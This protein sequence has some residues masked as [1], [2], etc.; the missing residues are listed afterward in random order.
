MSNFNR[1]QQRPYAP[2]P[3]S[4]RG[5]G[6]TG[7]GGKG[8]GGGHHAGQGGGVGGYGTAHRPAA[9]AFKKGRF[10]QSSFRVFVDEATPDVVEAVFNGDAFIEWQNVRQVDLFC[11]LKPRCPICLEE[12]MVVPK[13]TRCG[14]IFCAP[15]IMRYF[16]VLT[17]QNER[18]WQRCPVCNEERLLPAEDLTSV[19]FQVT[20]LLREN[21]RLSLLLVQREVSAT[22]VRPC[23]GALSALASSLGAEAEEAGAAEREEARAAEAVNLPFERD[24]GW[25]FSRLVRLGPGEAEELLEDE[26]MVLRQYRPF[27]VQGGE[28]E[29]L[30]SIDAA[31]KLVENRLR[32]LRELSGEDPGESVLGDAA[33][34]GRPPEGWGC[35]YVGVPEIPLTAEEKGGKGGRRRGHAEPG[36][37]TSGAEAAAAK[38]QPAE[39]SGEAEEV[40]EEALG[41]GGDVP[42]GG[43]G[44]EDGEDEAD[45]PSSAAASPGGGPQVAPSGS[46]SP[47]AGPQLSPPSPAS[48]PLPTPY[49]PRLVSFYQA[50]DGRLIFLQPFITR[51]L[52]HEHGG[53]WDQ[54]PPVL[55]GLR[56]EKLQDLTMTEESRRR[57]RFL[58]HLPLGATVLLADVDL[59]GLLSA[60]TREEFAEEFAKKRVQKKKVQARERRAEEWAKWGA[61][62]EVER[63]YQSLNVSFVERPVAPTKDDFAVDLHGRAVEE[64]EAG[65]EVE[66]AEDENGGDA[67][68]VEPEEEEENTMAKRIKEQMTR[69]QQGGGAKGAGRRKKEINVAEGYFPDLGSSSAAP[70]A[71]PAGGSVASGTSAAASPAAAAP[72][73]GGSSWG[74]G[75]GSSG[76][77]VAFSAQPAVAE[78]EE[79]TFG[80]VLEQALL[81]S[82]KAEDPASPAE[83]GLAAGG[84][85]KKKGKAK[86]TKIKLFG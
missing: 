8:H 84:G 63:Y 75:R 68:R 29:L 28:T 54:L 47:T 66:G 32:E 2:P 10:V 76:K 41:G 7:G 65:P 22:I 64:P 36:A 3:R 16:M 71:T 46:P 78:A 23:P 19:R 45:A 17:D 14:H 37:S 4:S 39:M 69:K 70:S 85:K 53:R 44:S 57:H 21:D 11:D 31:A 80:E 83:E 5:G 33:F 43:E 82:S 60:A 42:C 34:I 49:G 26:L 73:A 55:A 79:P 67:G 13:I 50:S 51:V 59:R 18:P 58:S 6:R 15:C 9:A 27:V 81:R 74:A 40:K 62:E 20:R 61:A 38:R 72:S 24:V 86:P 56:L 48:A 12:E 1:P 52:L 77:V 35:R 25:H 30:P